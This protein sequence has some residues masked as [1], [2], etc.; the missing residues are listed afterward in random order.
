[1][2]DEPAPEN[3][4]INGGGGGGGYNDYMESEF[5]IDTYD[6]IDNFIKYLCLPFWFKES[7]DEDDYY[8]N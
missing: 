6:H 5:Y 4:D 7:H 2:F 8:L 1:M 3:M